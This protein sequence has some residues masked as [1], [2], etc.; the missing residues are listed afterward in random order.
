MKVL[1]I[2]S[3]PSRPLGS[4]VYDGERH[5]IGRCQ[6]LMS[7]ESAE[8]A[9]LEVHAAIQRLQRQDQSA[10]CKEL[11]RLFRMKLSFIRLQIESGKALLKS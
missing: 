4:D 8:L 3:R 9:M 10:G 6:I 1:R 11:M 7:G 5:N 2:N